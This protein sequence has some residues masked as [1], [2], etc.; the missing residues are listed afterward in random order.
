MKNKK[1]KYKTWIELQDNKCPK[2][3]AD[4]QDGMFGEITGCSCGFI[5]DKKTKD[6][7]VKRDKNE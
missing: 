7:L 6:L 3:K 4:L 5:I 2:C 1:Q